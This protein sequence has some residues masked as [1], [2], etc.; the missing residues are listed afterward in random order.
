M[1]KRTEYSFIAVRCSVSVCHDNVGPD[2][3]LSGTCYTPRSCIFHSHALEEEMDSRRKLMYRG[4]SPRRF[5][6]GNV[7]YL[8]HNILSLGSRNLVC[9]TPKDQFYDS[10]EAS[11]RRDSLKP[12]KRELPTKINQARKLDKNRTYN[13]DHYTSQT[14]EVKPIVNTIF[15]K[16][17][18][19]PIEYYIKNKNLLIMAQDSS[20]ERRNRDQKV[21]SLLS[22]LKKGA[23]TITWPRQSKNPNATQRIYNK[24]ANISRCTT[25]LNSN[26]TKRRQPKSNV[27][28]KANHFKDS[29]NN[30]GGVGRQQIKNNVRNGAN[31]SLM[32]EAKVKV[33]QKVGDDDNEEDQR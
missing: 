20:K 13:F 16:D 9:S 1:H 10:F 12:P 21:A 26:L 25:P 18:S 27:V 14:P 6:P 17:E 31:K 32:S 3:E 28:P 29:L 22:E 7:N 8:D 5:V 11:S 24:P 4:R 2:L 33:Q 15:P 23:R 30:K 19:E